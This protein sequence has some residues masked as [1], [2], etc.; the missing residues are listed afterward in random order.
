[1]NV[2]VDGEQKGKLCHS[3]PSMH[4]CI[5]E[6]IVASRS[7]AFAPGLVALTARALIRTENRD[8]FSRCSAMPLYSHDMAHGMMPKSPALA[9]D[10]NMDRDCPAEGNLQCI[11][12]IFVWS[13]FSSKSDDNYP[14]L[15]VPAL[16]RIHQ[17][18][19]APRE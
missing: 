9:I 19:Q 10:P 13:S 14:T 8:P 18:R 5:P 11:V 6:A 2:H 12:S 4:A 17:F 15:D 7:C 16:K 1:M 3:F